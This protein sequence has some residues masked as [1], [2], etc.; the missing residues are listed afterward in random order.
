[1]TIA[2]AKCSCSGHNTA[3]Y[4]IIV[5]NS[6]VFRVFYRERKRE[7]KP[8]G[9]RGRSTYIGTEVQAGYRLFAANPVQSVLLIN[10]RAWRIWCGIELCFTFFV[11]TKVEAEVEVDWAIGIFSA[12]RD[13]TIP[14]LPHTLSP[15]PSTSILALH[16]SAA[17][18]EGLSV[19]FII[20]MQILTGQDDDRHTYSPARSSSLH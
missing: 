16:R 14:F 18:F 4:Q 8:H 7:V 17:H 13:N 1:M 2:C 10:S 3:T 15:L 11:G 12:S 20:I 5:L 9:R 6:I 19:L